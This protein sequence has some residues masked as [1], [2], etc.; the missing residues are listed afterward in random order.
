MLRASVA[1]SPPSW[2]FICAPLAELHAYQEVLKTA[3]LVV[4]SYVLTEFASTADGRADGCT[5]QLSHDPAS[6][7]RRL[8]NGR[9]RLTAYN[10]RSQSGP[11]PP[12]GPAHTSDHRHLRLA[13]QHALTPYHLFLAQPT[14]WSRP[15]Y[16]ITTH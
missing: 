7:V 14:T 15:C 11:D 9:R 12:P 4:F 8:D 16:L 6:I 10:S 3:D 5:A 13:M 1:P 2:S